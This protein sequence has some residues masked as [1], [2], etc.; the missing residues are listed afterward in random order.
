MIKRRTDRSLLFEG[1][2]LNSNSTKVSRLYFS[3]KFLI[4]THRRYS[5]NYASV[6]AVLL[7]RYFIN[8]PT[9]IVYILVPRYE[10]LSWTSK[11]IISFRKYLH[12][13]SLLYIHTHIYDIYITQT[14]THTYLY[15]NIYVRNI[16][17]LFMA[18][19]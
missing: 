8:L 9:L 14:H 19:E 7:A 1:K 10:I 17:Y 12:L 5:V 13:L 3:S 4:I 16:L 6:A 2:R 11:C 18:N 15:I